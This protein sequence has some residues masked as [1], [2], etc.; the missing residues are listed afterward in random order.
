MAALYRGN[1]WAIDRFNKLALGPSSVA[2]AFRTMDWKRRFFMSVLALCE[3]NAYLAYNAMAAE[4]SQPTLTRNEWKLA[5]AKALCGN[6]YSEQIVTKSIAQGSVPTVHQL[7]GNHGH[8]VPRA[9][10]KSLICGVCKQYGKPPYPR[11]HYQCGCGIYV[12]SPANPQKMCALLHMVD[13]VGA[14]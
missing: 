3:T 7:L 14:D 13:C 10:R 8:I 5:L 6:P 12:C 11:T 9:D 4:K 2:T 1:F